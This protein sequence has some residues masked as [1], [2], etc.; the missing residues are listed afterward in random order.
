VEIFLYD[1]WPEFDKKR[2]F[3]RVAN[4]AIE[5]GAGARAVRPP[6][7]MPESQLANA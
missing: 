3:E 2:L 4:M 7:T 5:T 1:W 6:D